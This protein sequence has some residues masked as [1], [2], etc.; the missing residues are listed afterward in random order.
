MFTPE[1]VH[2]LRATMV[3]DWGT[4]ADCAQ[5][6]LDVWFLDRGVSVPRLLKVVCAGCPVRRSC[7]ASAVLVG[8]VGVWAGTSFNNR[9]AAAYR[10]CDGDD[11]GQVLDQLLTAAEP[12]PRPA[13]PAGEPT[14]G[15]GRVAA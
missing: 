4:F 1:Q 11:V 8:E 12:K 14:D 5:G 10:I 13:L 9:E 6:G 7:L 15:A 2:A 3:R